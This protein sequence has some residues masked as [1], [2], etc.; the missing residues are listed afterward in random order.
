MSRF[1]RAVYE[2]RVPHALGIYLAAGWGLLEFTSW[3]A[4]RDLVAGGFVNVLLVVWL[5]GLPV[6][7][8]LAWRSGGPVLASESTPAADDASIAVLPFA[9]RSADPDDAFLADGITDEITT[10][11]ART[12]GLRVAS[13]TSAYVFKDRH[14]DIR[15]IGRALGVR[16]V[17]EGSVQHADERIRVSTQLVAVEDGYQLWSGRFDRELSDL[18]AIEDEIAGEV[19]DALRVLLDSKDR[20][21]LRKIPR[22]DIRAYQYYLRGRQYYYQ[23]RKKSLRFA[24]D[25][26]RRAIQ[27]DAEYALAHAALADTICMERTFYPASDVDLG[28]AERA[29]E[30]ALE[31][32]PALAEAHAA[33]GFVLFTQGRWEEA[34]TRF[35][36]AIRLDP[37]LGDA[38]YVF[39]RMRFQQGRMEEAARLFS[40]A[41]E[42]R[43][44]YESAF[45]AAQALEALGRDAEA[46]EQYLQGLEAAEHHMDLNPDDARAAT[47]R[48]VAS[49]RVGRSD[50]GLEWGRR[51]VE[52]D[53][54]DAGVR[55]NV[56]CL[57]AVAGERE[58]ALELLEQA[59]AAGF[60]NREWLERDPD[61]ESVR[62]ASRFQA[63]L[64]AMADDAE[65]VAD[66]AGSEPS[67][68]APAEPTP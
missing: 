23:T 44:G 16:T 51:A 9:N 7:A 50:A 68:P 8:I 13:R 17:L 56:A 1:A 33:R 64:D 27:I 4:E 62:D 26:F 43:D 39:G 31:L 36:A 24:R 25:M 2:R 40:E 11:L 18:F 28:E 12:S 52:I 59:V 48:A 37:K 46:Q 65:R 14:Q 58:R 10:A 29:S 49:F 42:L 22:A 32:N 47:M 60:G 3:A 66:A 55:Y 21:G 30:R 15:A 38:R 54:E 53:P 5:I 67:D 20:D 61:L 45:F 63:L 41:A 57:F 6:T 19:A 35:R 34:E